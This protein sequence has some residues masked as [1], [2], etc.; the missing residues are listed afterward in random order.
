MASP[1][2][3]VQYGLGPIGQATARTVHEK[4]DAA[5]TLAGAI[6]VDPQKVGRDVADLWDSDCAPTGVTVQSGAD[7]VLDET[8]PDVVLHTITSVLDGVHDQ[9]MQCLEVGAD[10]VSSTEELAFPYERHPE[11]AD[12]LERAAQKAGG[13][14]V[15]TGVNP[16]Y[17]MDT[18]PL[19]ATGVC[20]EV[21][22][23]HV[24]R[25]VDA[26]ER[27]APLQAKVGVGLT[28][29]AFE[30]KTAAGGFGHIGLRES[31][32]MLAEGL[33]W[34][35]E[36]IEESLQPVVADERV[37]TPHRTM[38]AGEVA[39]IHHV[40]TGRVHGTER[41]SLDLKMYVGADTPHDT[42]R[43]VGRPPIDLTIDGGIFGDTATVGMLVNTAPLAVEAASGLHT[44]ADL[45]V[46]RAF[47]T[48]NEGRPPSS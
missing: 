4:A 21:T 13:T 22:A 46:P 47:G 48:L 7:A 41:L 17:A 19:S 3:V 26:G 9:L 20:T 11:R 14:L 15:G 25:V 23:V 32:Q 16:G 44:M 2:R 35:V 33:G 12:A 29:E 42:V 8:R 24:E 5:M 40:A 18:L 30:E 36:A 43:V 28:T 1:L 38:A 6:D 34:P 37:A 31:L 10:V 39:G 45:P 27:R